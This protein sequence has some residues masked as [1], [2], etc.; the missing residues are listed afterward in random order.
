MQTITANGAQ[1][2]AIGLGVMTL[3]DETCVKAVDAALRMG[4]RHIDTAQM[5]GNEREVG[6]GLRASGVAREAVFVTTK[7]WHDRLKAGDFERSVDESLARLGLPAVDLLLIHWP[8]KDVPLKETIDA[9]CRTKRAGKTR[10]VGVANFTVALTDEAARLA[11]EPLVTNQIEV[12]PFIDRSKV[13]AAC[14]RHGLSVT[15]YCP[16]ARGAVPGDAALARIGAAHGKSPAQ[17]SLRYLVQRGIVP[18]P[19]SARP[20]H[21]AENLAVFDFALSDEEMAELDRL[22]SANKRI[23]NPPH[24]PQWDG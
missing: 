15:A 6:E 16:I 3:K 23:V 21:L 4:Y 18:I 12:H 17:V 20:E 13:I 10:H 2:P 8:N 22:A 11:S 9:L 5:Y 14:R 24:A 1:I 7:V 19:R